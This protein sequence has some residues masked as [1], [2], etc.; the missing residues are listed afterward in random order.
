MSEYKILPTDESTGEASWHEG[1][2]RDASGTSD[3]A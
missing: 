1:F 2:W 3:D